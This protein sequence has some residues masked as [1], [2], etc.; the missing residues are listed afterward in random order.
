M[1]QTGGSSGAEEA[2]LQGNLDGGNGDGKFGAEG[3]FF[4]HNLF[5][6]CN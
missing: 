3:T 6:C 5:L 1:I 2:G 4:L